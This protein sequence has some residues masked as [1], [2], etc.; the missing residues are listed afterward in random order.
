MI[1]HIII[2]ILLVYTDERD[3]TATSGFSAIVA[4]NNDQRRS[5]VE[6]MIT[7]DNVYENKEQFFL[8]LADLGGSFALPDNFVLS[9]NMSE[10]NILDNESKICSCLEIFADLLFLIRA[11]VTVGFI[12]SPYSVRED[13]GPMIFTVGV[14]SGHT[15]DRDIELSFSTADINIGGILLVMLN[16]LSTIFMNNLHYV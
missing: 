9:P 4:F 7:D 10:I 11:V 8:R 6:I 12:D 1:Q 14:T 15:L 13:E 2:T 5:C 16:C 3:Y